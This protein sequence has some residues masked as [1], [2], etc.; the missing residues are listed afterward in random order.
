MKYKYKYV[1][2]GYNYL[3]TDYIYI[4]ISSCYMVTSM[5]KFRK[6]EQYRYVVYTVFG[7]LEV[8]LYT[9]R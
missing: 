4:A 9:N 1:G 3:N 7:W 2:S 8:F 6:T 5:Y